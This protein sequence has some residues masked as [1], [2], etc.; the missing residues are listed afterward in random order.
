VWI[1]STS[2]LVKA[3]AF[4]VPGTTA[5]SR[6]REYGRL[7]ECAMRSTG[8]P[9]LECRIEQIACRIGGKDCTIAVGQPDPVDGQKV[10][11]IIDLG[12]HLPYGVFTTAD[13][14]APAHL[15]GKKIY[16]MTTFR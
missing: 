13:A 7:Q 11:A 3:S 14:D 12:R 10:V 16:S 5:R 6:E 9:P 2:D 15:V 4:F 8:F 1:A